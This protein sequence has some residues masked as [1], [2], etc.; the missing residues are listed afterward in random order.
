MDPLQWM[1]AVRMRVQTADNN[2]TSNNTTPLQ[3]SPSVNILWSEKLCVRKKQIHYQGVFQFKS[4]KESSIH[5][6][7]FS[8]EKFTSSESGGKYAQMTH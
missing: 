5:N 7:T 3:S 4:P 8:S 6:I 2:I 1:G